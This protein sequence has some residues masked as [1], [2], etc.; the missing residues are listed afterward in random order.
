MS[1]DDGQ[2]K[3]GRGLVFPDGA[4]NDGTTWD[5]SAPL[6]TA[7]QLRN[8]H[9]FGIPLFS[10][11]RH[12][13]TGQLAEFT[14]PMIEDAIQDAAAKVEFETG[15]TL[16]P[17]SFE[18]KPPFDKHLY[19]SC[20]YLKTKNRPVMS[21]ELL[22]VTPSNE[23]DIFDVPIEWI[24]TANLHRGQVN[25]I[26]Y[27]IAM[28]RAGTAVPAAGS[29]AAFLSGFG[30]KNWIA[31]FWRIKYTAGFPSGKV[32]KVVNELIGAVAAMEILSMLASTYGKGQSSSLSIDGMSQSSSSPGPEIFTRRLK[33]LADKR[34]W[35]TSKLKAWAGLKL[36]VGTI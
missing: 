20:F 1:W 33:D 29:G 18:E 8:K 14:D 13:V 21:I 27:S 9:L 15:L 19:D 4:N 2:S 5:R 26:P 34:V 35:L 24:E 10:N 22:R 12:P 28:T 23:Q 25:V 7:E 32:P 31:A 36:M 11:L 30:W 3:G 6:I 17:T 16:F